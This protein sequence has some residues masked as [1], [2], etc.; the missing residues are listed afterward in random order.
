MVENHFNFGRN[1]WVLF[2]GV[3]KRSI[4]TDLRQLSTSPQIEE[5]HEDWKLGKHIY[6]SDDDLRSELQ[7]SAEHHEDSQF[8]CSDRRLIIREMADVLHLN[9]RFYAFH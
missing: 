3:S 5:H 2:K 4:L 9:L 1:N 6:Q 7:Q 8:M